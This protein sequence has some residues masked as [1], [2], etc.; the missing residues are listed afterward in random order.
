MVLFLFWALGHYWLQK[1]ELKE[2]QN[3]LRPEVTFELRKGRQ[4]IFRSIDQT[5]GFSVANKLVFHINK[6]GERLLIERPLSELEPMLA[7]KGFFRVNR[8]LLLSRDAVQSYKV[9]N[10]ERIKVT[11]RSVPGMPATCIVSRYKAP[12][13]RK[14][15]A[16]PPF[17][18]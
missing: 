13:F 7:G 18:F 3:A 5:L 8:Q 16:N 14:W 17:G 4:T 1:L 10:N 15:L 6:E 11:M 9:I 2:T 12:A